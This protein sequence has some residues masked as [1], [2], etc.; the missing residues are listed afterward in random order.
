MRINFD[1]IT[2]ND[3]CYPKQL[4]TIYD[5]PKVLY[6]RG[7]KEIIENFYCINYNGTNVTL[8]SHPSLANEYETSLIL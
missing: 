4:K 7:N 3:K 8:Y 5:P 2:I 1:K 6:V